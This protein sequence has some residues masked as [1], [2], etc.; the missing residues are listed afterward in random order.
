MNQVPDNYSAQIKIKDTSE[1]L[2]LRIIHNIKSKACE[3]SH[4]MIIC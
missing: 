3:S 2:L 1:A 4:P